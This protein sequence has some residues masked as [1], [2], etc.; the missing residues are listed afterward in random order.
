[1]WKVISENQADIDGYLRYLFC[2]CQGSSCNNM[3]T[4]SGQ[5]EYQSDCSVPQT[6]QTLCQTYKSSSGLKVT[7]PRRLLIYGEQLHFQLFVGNVLGLQSE[8]DIINVTVS[9]KPQLAVRM[10]TPTLTVRRRT[11]VEIKL[12]VHLPDCGYGVPARPNL[13]YEWTW[14]EVGIEVVNPQTG[15]S[16]RGVVT[17]KTSL[18]ILPYTLGFDTSLVYFFNATV[19]DSSGNYEGTTVS[20]KVK[21]IKEPLN[22]SLSGNNAVIHYKDNISLSA[23]AIDPMANEDDDKGTFKWKCFQIFYD[24]TKVQSFDVSGFTGT[25]I[26]LTP[27]SNQGFP[28][29]KFELHLK[30]SKEFRETQASVVL[31]IANSATAQ[32]KVLRP[33]NA[34]VIQHRV[35]IGTKE[36]LHLHADNVPPNSTITWF[37]YKN[38][39]TVSKLQALDDYILTEATNS[40]DLIIRAAAFEEGTDYDFKVR[41]TSNDT[42]TSEALLTVAVP[43]SPKGGHLSVEPCQSGGHAFSTDFH[44][45]ARDWMLIG[46]E[47]S[48]MELEYYFG[49]NIAGT[50]VYLSAIYTTA[51][52]VCNT[53]IYGLLVFRFE[54]KTLYG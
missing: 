41:V 45:D 40:C 2:G 15:S 17:R 22:L 18:F 32:I 13:E 52:E 39:D 54:L 12:S 31:R 14:S 43:V 11:L 50:T 5:K 20:A 1:M 29:G 25:N 46:Q 8:S 47:E 51:N 53:V 35:Y 27:P 48:N 7:V 9:E 42:D 44:I 49:Y 30:W 36:I 28:I 38:K 37:I 33:R 3:Y 10:L 21:V 4:S 6:D 24:G 19:T 26:L 16:Q 23:N 34:L